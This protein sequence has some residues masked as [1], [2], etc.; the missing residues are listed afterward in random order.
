MRGVDRATAYAL[1]CRIIQGASGLLSLAV[2]AWKLDPQA[3]GAYFTI[4]ALLQMQAAAELG[5]SVVLIQVASHECAGAVDPHLGEERLARLGSLFRQ[6]LSWFGAATALFFIVLA[7]TGLW[8]FGSDA[9]GA[10]V[11]PWLLAVTCTAAN[12]MPIPLLAVS[13]GSGR[14]T[15]AWRI[16]LIQQASMATVLIGCLMAG[17]GTWSLGVSSLAGLVAVLMSLAGQEAAFAARL[18]RAGPSAEPLRWMTSVW[19]F[20]W[21]ITLSFLSGIFIVLFAVPSVYRICGAVEAGKFG[22]AFSALRGICSVALANIGTKAQLLGSL[23]AQGERGELDRQFSRACRAS[24][25]LAGAGMTA[26]LL[27][28]W[29]LHAL[30]LPWESRLPSMSVILILAVALWLQHLTQCQAIYLRAHRREPFLVPSLIG[31]LLLGLGFPLSAA[32]GGVL[33]VSLCFLAVTLLL[34]T[35][36]G[37]LLFRSHGGSANKPSAVE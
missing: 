36:V 37:T 1:A 26:F 25:A 34:G 21:R 3:Q 19:P 20:Q 29:S 16:R 5:L 15:G 33:G 11:G 14:V 10:Q 6:A 23:V 12:M 35:V 18:M 13:E 27:A 2:V 32:S 24:M 22:L 28:A 4:G 30:S 7:P 31:A 9:G 8:L 17:V